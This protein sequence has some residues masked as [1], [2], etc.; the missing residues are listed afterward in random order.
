MGAV[1]IF[2][3]VI[4]RAPFHHEALYKCGVAMTAAGRRLDAAGIFE[5]LQNYHSDD[6]A[7]MQ[8]AE[9]ARSALLRLQLSFVPAEAS[10]GSM[11]FAMTEPEQ[12]D[13]GMPP[14]RLH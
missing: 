4:Q 11:M 7:N 9:K 1:N 5:T 8:Y 10:H 6:M 3:D 13:P 14:K 2:E 12:N